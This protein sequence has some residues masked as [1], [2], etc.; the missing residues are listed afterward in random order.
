M[1]CVLGNRIILNVRAV[2]QEERE[3]AARAQSRSRSE[4]VFQPE[5]K[6]LGEI[7]IEI[8]MGQCQLRSV[9][10]VSGADSVQKMEPDDAVEVMRELRLL[11]DYNP[12]LGFQDPE[13]LC[14][15]LEYPLSFY[16]K[17][18]DAKLPLK[19]IQ[20]IP[21]ATYL[22][23][24]VDR[25]IQSLEDEDVSLSRRHSGESFSV[26]ASRQ[27]K[28]PDTSIVDARA[29]AEIYQS[30]TASYTSVVAPTL[31]LYIQAPGWFTKLD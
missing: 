25:I 22:S 21:L 26:E 13:D 1:S 18:L 4:I 24:T 9:S 7:E 31:L 16:E 5:E 17:H 15:P 28:G 8:E 23:Q 12:P 3:R 19:A 30:T 20:I 27:C 14:P 6:S 29:L 2:A 10:A 11:M